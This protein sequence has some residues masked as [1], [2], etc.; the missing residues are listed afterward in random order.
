MITKIRCQNQLGKVTHLWLFGFNDIRNPICIMNSRYFVLFYW[1]MVLQLLHAQS[2]SAPTNL[3]AVIVSANGSN[4]DT[5]LTWQD[6]SSNESGF[7]FYKKSLSGYTLLGS[8]AQPNITSARINGGVARGENAVF[9]IRSYYYN[10][11]NQ[12]YYFLDIVDFPAVRG[13]D[14]FL[15]S[16]SSGTI[17][18]PLSQQ[19]LVSNPQSVLQ[20]TASGLPSWLSI[21]S[22][23]GVLNGV[24]PQAGIFTINLSIT[25]ADGWVLNGT[26]VLRIRP[27]AG[28]P[29]SANAVPNWTARTGSSRNTSLS[30]VFTDAE[31]ESAVRVS[32]NLGNFDLILFNNAT[33][34]T[35]INF[36]SYVNSGKYNNVAFHRSIPGFVVQGGGFRGTGQ[37][38]QFTSIPPSPPILNEPGISNLR[39]TVAMAKIGGNPD[40]ATNQFF[41][42]TGNNA[43]NLDNQNGGFTVFG[44]VAGNGMTVVDAIN[45]LPRATYSLNLDG[46]LSAT[47][48]TDFPMNAATAPTV[49][50]QSKLVTMLSVVPI[51]TMTYS[52]TGNSDPSVATA[53]IVDGEL[54]L[55]SLKAGQCTISLTATDLDQLSTSQQISI[56]INDTYSTWATRT[57]FP[58]GQSDATQNPDGDRWNNLLEYAFGE[59]PAAASDFVGPTLGQTMGENQ[60]AFLSLQFPLR[61]FTEGLVYR[62]EANHD[63]DGTWT[64][65]WNSTQ[66][67]QHVRVASAVDQNDRTVVTI[68]DVNPIGT[69]TRRFLRL[70]V[71]QN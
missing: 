63:L 52:I 47:S 46:S 29:V 13:P 24:P 64:E 43:S 12:L 15:Q 41:V 23:T 56:Q 48:F 66:G 39:G 27:S 16:A 22:S 38:T 34:G 18:T 71:S 67:L 33:P 51:P 7:A 17:G 30:G 45:N 54:R 50:D 26:Y 42:N 57:N 4:W 68:R 65:I 6:T 28:A 25:Y 10:P 37:S 55:Q 8:L 9:G 58:N 62:V 31:A 20:Y 49:M 2:P 14:V 19:I 35:V 70:K 44:R 1:V 60:N 11:S 32:T 69:T 21:N 5:D 3:N 40:S 61:K 53:G 59:N 36:M